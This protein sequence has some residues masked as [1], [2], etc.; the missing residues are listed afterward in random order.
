MSERVLYGKSWR[1][2]RTLANG[3][4][5]KLELVHNFALIQRGGFGAPP[6]EYRTQQSLQGVGERV[7]DYQVNT[8]TVTFE[9]ASTENAT[10][11]DLDA[12]R[13]RLIE[14][15]KPNQVE[16]VRAIITRTDGSSRAI[17][18]RPLDAAAF[19][20]AEAS[21]LSF[22]EPT[23]WVAHDPIWFDPRPVVIELPRSATIQQAQA[24]FAVSSARRI[25]TLSDRS[26]GENLSYLW[27][28]GDGS[29][30]RGRDP[31]KRY[32]RDGAYLIRLTVY[33]ELAQSSRSQRVVIRN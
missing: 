10:Q 21:G 26:R 33:N 1:F 31:V 32:A 6:L 24:D 5:D 25:V 17:H 3:E 14:F 2:E 9:I 7:L 20:P 12:A 22:L 16:P 15:A 4:I 30:D 29:F 8:R 13:R 18:I 19:N 27:N 11:A 23:T 28:F